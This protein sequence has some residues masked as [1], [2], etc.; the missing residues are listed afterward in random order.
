MSKLTLLFAA[1]FALAGCMSTPPASNTT[2]EIPAQAPAKPDLSSAR[3]MAQVKA[4]ADDRLEGRAPG[5]KGETLTLEYLESEF[6]RIGLQP[7]NGAS[8]RQPVPMIELTPD[9]RAMALNVSGKSTRA[10]K[11]GIDFV[12]GSR[13]QQREIVLKDVEIVFAGYGVDAAEHQWNDFAGL[14]VKGK[15]LVVLINDPGFGSKDLSLFKGETMTYYGRWTYKFE[16]A[17]K[18][19]AAGVLIVHDTDGAA[20]GWEVVQ[21]GWLK[22]LYDVETSGPPAPQTQMQ[23]WL[24]AAAA[25]TLFAD[26]G[27]DFAELKTAADV[28]GFK[29]RTLGLTASITINNTIRR[30]TSDNLIALLPGREKPDEY[31]IYMAHWDHLGRNFAA[32][33]DQIMNGAIDN[34]TGVAGVLE[35]ATAFVNGPRPSRSVL[36]FL[37][38]LEES[39]LLGSRYYAEHP[40]V[41]LNKTV[42]GLNIDAMSLIGPTNDV[43]VTGF[44]SSEMEDILRRYAQ[45]Q[46]RTVEAEPTPQDGF[47][48]RSDHFSFAKVGVPVL[49]AEG[50]FDHRE[51]GKEFGRQSAADYV[52]NRYHKPSD[53]F[54]PGWDSRGALEDLTLL[55]QVGFEVANSQQ[56]PAWYE[57]SEFRMV[58]EASLKQ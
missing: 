23:G 46:A 39:G 30:S 58:R 38:T 44:G 45:A 14:D 48:F 54:D 43:V 22:P 18:L 29:A 53:E 16:Q 42:A 1:T 15:L 26:A 36:F 19:G 20:Y 37:P 52:T 28:R 57:N 31:V 33:Q 47:F 21:N 5:T 35:I 17:A 27:L 40:I 51:K 41:A 4:I 50:G 2:A 6:R 34:A 55:Y 49:Y 9:R 13:L 24:S 25:S 7:G 8:F 10:L 3:F 11:Y 32:G 12:A 56:W